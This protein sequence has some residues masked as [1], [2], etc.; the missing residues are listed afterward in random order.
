MKYSRYA[1]PLVWASLAAACIATTP[2]P[3]DERRQQVENSLMLAVS[4]EGEDHYYTLADRMKRYGVPGLSFALI[5]DGEIEWAAG[6]GLRAAGSSEPVT[7]STLFQAASIAKPLVAAAVLRMQD[8]GLI[9]IDVDAQEYLEDFAIPQ[10]EQTDSNRVTFRKLLSHTAGITPGGYPGYARGEPLPTDLEIVN[11]SSPSNTPP[12]R[13]VME[14]GSAVAYS[15]GGYTIVELALQDITEL[16]FSR[17]MDEWVLSVIGLERSTYSQPLDEALEDE[18]ALGH[19]P[20][21]TAVPGGWR[22]HPEQAA[23]GLWTIASDLA[24]F[25]IELRNAYLGLGDLLS[26]GAAV[27]MLTDQLDGEG[28]GVRVS[29]EGETLRFTHAGGNA[30][31]RAY[32]IMHV[33]SGDGAA[34]LAN[35]DLGHSVGRELLRAASA[36]YDWPGFKSRKAS[37]V[38]LDRTTLIGLQGIY[39]F[40]GEVQ[41]VIALDDSAD[42]LSITFP[43][44]DVYGLVPVGPLN[45]VDPETGVTV[46]FEGTDEQRTVVTYGDTGV[47]V[48]N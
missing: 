18:A 34:Y 14:P 39:D 20:D 44:G 13:V 31:Y 35:S 3:V 43:N 4:F 11:G 23:A 30:G 42:Q 27:E 22:V 5:N 28:I 37:R 45:F 16:P 7:P 1:A 17:L 10:G 8:A 38:A 24:T 48:Q 36:V 26:Q 6:Y 46:D 15:G 9:D 40:G 33:A 2:D 29:G 12:A 32:L 41:V 21:G 47:R 25:A 19:F